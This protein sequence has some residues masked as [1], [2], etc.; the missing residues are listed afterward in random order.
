MFDTEVFFWIDTDLA[1]ITYHDRCTIKPNQTEPNQSKHWSSI[2]RPYDRGGIFIWSR[3]L[4]SELALSLFLIEFPF[5]KMSMSRVWPHL[6]PKK[7][8]LMIDN[9]K[10]PSFHSPSERTQRHSRFYKKRATTLKYSM[11]NNCWTI[12]A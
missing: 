2:N 1:S 5:S 9:L 4:D 12:G 8:I 6:A 11:K 3:N 7:S 10:R